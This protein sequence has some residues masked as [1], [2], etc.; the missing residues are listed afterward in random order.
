[1]MRWL[2]GLS[3]LSGLSYL[4]RHAGAALLVP[5]AAC[6]SAHYAINPPLARVEPQQGYRL[7][8]F[9]AQEPQD[10]LLLHVSF[11]GGGLRAATLGLGV[12]DEL[13]ATPIDWDGRQQRLF[14]QIDIVSGLSGGS[15]LVGALAMGGEAGLAPFE[16]ALL[17]GAAQSAFTRSL[18]APATL[19]RLS[20]PHYGRSDAFEQFLDERLFHGT[21]FADLSERPRKPFAVIFASDMV[22][23]GRFEFV[24]EQFDFLC[25]D[26]GGVKLVRAVAASSAVPLLLSPVTFWNH[27][28]DPRRPDCGAPLLRQA[29]SAQGAAANS[30]R[31]DELESYR[32]LESDGAAAGPRRPFI[33]VVDGGLDD[34]VSARGPTD[35]IGQFGGIVS[36]A[37]F[38][39]YGSLRRVVF[40]VV[41]AETSARAPEDR[42]A[43]VPGPLRTALALA[44]IPINRNS[45]TALDQ[46]R[47]TIQAWRLEVK[48]AQARGEDTPF[49]S[50]IAFHLIEVG[51][52]AAD[53]A[54][55]ERLKA[56]PTTLQ[57]PEADIAVL[58]QHARQRLRASPQFRAMLRSLQPATAQE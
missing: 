53:P 55:A 39:G 10:S 50:D 23:G 15:M 25:S 41:N 24:Q 56:I 19:W 33:H 21:T 49:A 58:R 3:G 44:D 6:S 4:L 46:M 8:R 28:G 9:V 43:R 13:R 38:A 35:Y 29:A 17:H 12:L 2:S 16:A 30:R 34:N 1:M 51:L 54:L 7:Q 26:L 47:A 20:S 36:S 18:L 14:D 40:I 31:L 37:R 57:L 22:S 45:A 42:S 48:Q 11:S 5:L 32:E 52:D 27:V